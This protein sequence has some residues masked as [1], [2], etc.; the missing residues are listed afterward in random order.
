ME[1]LYV[2]LQQINADYPTMVAVHSPEYALV[3]LLMLDARHVYQ[4]L[5][6]ILLIL[7][8]RVCVSLT[9]WL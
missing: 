2:F 9:L 6:K 7:R 8:E 1:L 5:L 3:Q 4:A